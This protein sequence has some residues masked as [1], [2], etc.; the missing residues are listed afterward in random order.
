M[1]EGRYK[2]VF[3]GV[4]RNRIEVISIRFQNNIISVSIHS[5]SIADIIENIYFFN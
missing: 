2:S 1:A 4:K 3:A 5:I